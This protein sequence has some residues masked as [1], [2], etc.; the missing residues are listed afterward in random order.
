MEGT[1]SHCKGHPPL[2]HSDGTGY[3]TELLLLRLFLLHRPGYT[4]CTREQGCCE[5]ISERSVSKF[6]SSTFFF[7]FLV[8]WLF[9]LDKQNHYCQLFKRF[10][11]PYDQTLSTF[12]NLAACR[13][14]WRRTLLT[15]HCNTKLLAYTIA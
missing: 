9:F 5:I 13:E 6:F 10:V 15:I 2:F 8:S 4:L 3:S 12:S 1:S 14:S 7:F 11:R